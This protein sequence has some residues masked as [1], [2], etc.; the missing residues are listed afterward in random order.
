MTRKRDEIKCPWCLEVIPA[1][2]VGVSRHENEFG[3]VLERTCGK[4]GR[5]LSAYLEE[6][7]SFLPKIRNF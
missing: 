5:T 7:G 4:C 2:K 3:T 6:E 1:S